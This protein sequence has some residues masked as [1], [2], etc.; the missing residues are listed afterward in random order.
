MTLHLHSSLLAAPV[1][2]NRNAAYL[3]LIHS[4]K[5][6]NWMKPSFCKTLLQS[7]KLSLTSLHTVKVFYR[8]LSGLLKYNEHLSLVSFRF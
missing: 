8:K 4:Q 7:I 6:L 2:S 1:N 3:S 5:T